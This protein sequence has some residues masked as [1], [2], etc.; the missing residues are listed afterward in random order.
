MYDLIP[1]DAE[2]NSIEVTA[3]NVSK[4][5]S[6]AARAFSSVADGYKKLSSGND[7]ELQV[8]K[9]RCKTNTIYGTH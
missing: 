7:L 6:T 2:E 9:V 4:V 5:S 3:A 8:K 1:I